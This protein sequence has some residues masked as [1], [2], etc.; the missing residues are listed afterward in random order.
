MNSKEALDFINTLLVEKSQ[1]VLNDLETKIFVGCWE[2]KEY[3]DIAANTSFTEQYLRSIGSQLF[4]K[5]K[6]ELG[7]KVSKKNF[8][9]PIEYKYQQLKNSPNTLSNINITEPQP[10]SNLQPSNSHSLPV[11]NGNFNPFQPTSGR[12]R[13]SQFFFARNHD[14]QEIFDILN[15]GS[16][17]VLIGEEGIGKSSL[18]AAICREANS[19]F[20]S[21]RQAVFIDLNDV[22]SEEEFYSTLC[23]E[24]GIE[25]CVG[26]M[27]TRNLR[28]YKIL[29]ALDNVG[30]MVCDGFTRNLRDKLRSWAEGGE[31]L[32]LVLAAHE[33]LNDLFNDNE[34][35]T[36]PLAGVCMP[37]QILP[38]D[39]SE[40]R[41]FIQ[42][43]LNLTRVAFSEE[44]IVGIINS[45]RGHPRQLMQLCDR[46]Y[47]EKMNFSS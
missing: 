11:N 36:S 26:Q 42:E 2:G 45:T 12:I 10:Q 30:K 46:L 39:E 47:R 21:Q 34:G 44:E 41:E 20:I 6:D 38:W 7:I 4:K 27:L 25:D 28:K 1:V 22:D 33:S 24:I 32:K 37:K 35:R 9:S 13:E 19:Y 43:K 18:L 23:H 40:M 29:L 8:I 16:S 15:S 31:P 17:I 3:K 5:I 14:I